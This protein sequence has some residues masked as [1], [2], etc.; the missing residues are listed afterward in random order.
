[1]M[2]AMDTTGMK[3]YHQY[4]RE[5]LVRCARPHRHRQGRPS[6]QRLAAMLLS[7]VRRPT[8]SGVARGRL[9]GRSSAGQA[10][11]A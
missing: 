5:G 3:A 9:G 4:R 8:D 11:A 6:R 1:M 10:T 2:Y 7:V